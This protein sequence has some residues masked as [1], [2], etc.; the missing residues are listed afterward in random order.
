MINAVDALKSHKRIDKFKAQLPLAKFVDLLDGI[1]AYTIELA[2]I[3]EV[4]LLPEELHESGEVLLDLQTYLNAQ[5]RIFE[6]TA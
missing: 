3:N 6:A 2:A 4:E 1:Q 5:K